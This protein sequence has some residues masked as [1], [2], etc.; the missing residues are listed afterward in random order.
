M[1]WRRSINGSPP[2]LLPVAAALVAARGGR[3]WRVWME[4]A[5]WSGARWRRRDLDAICYQRVGTGNI[6]VHASYLFMGNPF[7]ENGNILVLKGFLTTTIKLSLQNSEPNTSLVWLLRYHYWKEACRRWSKLPW[8]WQYYLR[9][10]IESSLFPILQ[11]DTYACLDWALLQDRQDGPLWGCHILQGHA[12]WSHVGHIA[13][14]VLV[15][16][17]ISVS[18]IHP[19]RNL[20]IML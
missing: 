8:C 20:E 12:L 3:W 2:V 14:V 19:L 6:S 17:Y 15:L 1:E 11:E 9:G 7:A 10:N 18:C 13:S 4:K 5:I 16:K